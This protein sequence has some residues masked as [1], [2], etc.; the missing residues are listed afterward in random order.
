MRVDANILVC[1]NTGS[2][3][4][5]TLNALLHLVP[6]SERLVI[7]EETP[8]IRTL[9]RHV[10]RLTA[11]PPSKIGL[12]DLVVDS[13]RMRPDRLMVGEVRSSAEVG[14]FIDTILA[15]QGRGSLATFHAQGVREAMLRLVKLGVNEL[16][17]GALDL[18]IVQRRWE[19][20]DNTNLQGTEIRRVTEI[21]EVVLDEGHPVPQTLFAYDASVDA[22]VRVGASKR[23]DEKFARST[24][25]GTE[26]I[27]EIWAPSN[28]RLR[29]LVNHRLSAAEFFKTWHGPSDRGALSPLTETEM[30]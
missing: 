20:L 28:E 21:S 5:T 3:K 8:E 27:P 11:H 14:A 24:G 7:I 4:T 22:L 10:V 9:H 15:G 29:E 17:L 12:G 16:D 23:L 19:K 30:E 26:K 1:G 6:P 13:L 2:G 18:V 25:V